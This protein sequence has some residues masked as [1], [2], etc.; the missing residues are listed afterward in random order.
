MGGK[1]LFK[2]S[3]PHDQSWPPHPYMVKTLKKSWDLVC[4]IE[5]V[6]P[7]YQVCSNDYPRLTL[8]YLMSRSTLHPNT[9]KQEIF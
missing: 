2:W 3:W 4:S 7:I 1:S 6:G 8:T 9:F 5:D